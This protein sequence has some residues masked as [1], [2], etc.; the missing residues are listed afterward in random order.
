MKKEWVTYCVRLLVLLVL[1]CQV[2]SSFADTR[3]TRDY[4]SGQNAIADNVYTSNGYGPSKDYKI[5]NSST[6]VVIQGD[7]TIGS[8][9]HVLVSKGATLIVEGNLYLNG[10][11]EI[12]AGGNVTVKKKLYGTGT[13]DMEYV[14]TSTGY[15]TVLGGLGENANIRYENV[16]VNEVAEDIY[17]GGKL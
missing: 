2:S 12:W 7:F 16:R 5:E 17:I 14:Q 13:L 9:T 8:N 11:L 4:T 15:L 1:T 10:E 3:L 6:I